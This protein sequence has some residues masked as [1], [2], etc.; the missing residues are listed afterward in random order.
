MTGFHNRFIRG[1]V[2]CSL[3]FSLLVSCDKT[4]GGDEYK[5]VP[6][7]EWGA[8]MPAVK[9]YMSRYT[10]EKEDA[11]N[12]YYKGWDKQKSISYH[13]E[14]GGLITS[15]VMFRSDSMEKSA[16]DAMMGGYENIGEFD[17]AQIYVSDELDAVGTVETVLSGGVS[18]YAV[19]WTRKSVE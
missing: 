4:S 19:G 9:A 11:D 6:Y 1:A 13:F 5:P 17:G 2:L 16:I 8:G 10:L 3:V 14:D 15:L 18:Y 12:L 7:M